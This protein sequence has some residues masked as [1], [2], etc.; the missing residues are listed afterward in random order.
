LPLTARERRM[1]KQDVPSSSAA[2]EY[3]LRANEGSRDTHHWH[4]ALALYE[5]CVAEDP[6][7]APGWAGLG[8]MQ[9]LI[10]K[11]IGQDPAERLGQ[12]EQALRRALELNP[13][14]SAA[15]NAL[16]HLDVDLGRAEE[17]MVRL[18]RRAQ[19]RPADPELYAGLAHACRYCGLMAASLAATEQARRLDPRI[20]TS[21]A[22]THFAL[23]DYQRTLDFQAES[24]PYM[25]NLA[26]IMLGRFDE[27]RASLAAIDMA[28][29]GRLGFFCQ[30]LLC[31]IDGRES[32][33]LTNLRALRDIPDPEG[34]FYIARLMAYYGLADE[35]LPIL[36][37]AVEDGFFCPAA[38]TR[39]PWL[40][41][42]RGRPEFTALL[43]RAEARHRQALIS[44]LQADG[45]RVLGVAHP[46]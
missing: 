36:A 17:A 15:E 9:R 37:A 12:A 8:R 11:Y 6:H 27:A 39:D 41:P 2:Y 32:D 46:V 23:G 35:A 13:D 14:L 20:R 28:A 38:Y 10:A 34:R 5:R 21:G 45:D 22:I 40:D 43:R 25:R 3:Y 42:V 44:F 7:Y 19:N 33:A 18:L 30:S 4:E 1:L 31:L 26:L 24:V 16:A 29:A